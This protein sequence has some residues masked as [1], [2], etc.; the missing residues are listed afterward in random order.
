MSI[1][2]QHVLLYSGGLDS[3]ITAQ[4]L[5]DAKLLYVDIGNAYGQVELLSMQ[6]N[7]KRPVEICRRLNLSGLGDGD[8][9]HATL[10]NR[11]LLFV[12]MAAY[13]GTDIVLSGTAGDVHLDKDIKFAKLATKLLRHMNRNSNT[14]TDIPYKVHIPF[15]RTTKREMVRLY[16]KECQTTLP[17]IKARSCHH[18]TLQHCGRCLPCLR[19]YFA[20]KANG[21][22]GCAWDSNPHDSF[23][24]VLHLIQQGRW[25]QRGTEDFETLAFLAQR[26]VPGAQRTLEERSGWWRG[27]AAWH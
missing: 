19:K 3:V 27:I 26:G 21:V 16:L 11:N 20:L 1:P 4:F 6:A 13:Y 17:L 10:V 14:G 22:G 5:P 12:L 15:A 24:R 25:T 7:T 18:P 8:A 9:T 2:K 23:E